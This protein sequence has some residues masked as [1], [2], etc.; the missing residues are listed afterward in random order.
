M[1]DLSKYINGG[2]LFDGHYRLIKL[3]STKGGT[4]YVWLAESY[5]YINTKL[6]EDSD[7][8]IR[9]DGTGVLVAIKI[10]RPKNIL[11]FD[12]EQSFRLDFKTIFPRHHANFISTTDYSI[13]DGIPLFCYNGSGESL[14]G[15]LNDEDDVWKIM[16]TVSFG[17]SYLHN[18]EPPIIH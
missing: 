4:A 10:H 9:V 17:L 8:V 3:L 15:K 14:K 7:D 16:A 5:E 11:N 6:S 18:L 13:Y 12:G 2:V 1:Q